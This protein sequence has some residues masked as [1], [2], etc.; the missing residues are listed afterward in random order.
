MNKALVFSP[1]DSKLIM[2]KTNESEMLH[3]E[4]LA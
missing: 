1:E 3:V 2:G 4:V